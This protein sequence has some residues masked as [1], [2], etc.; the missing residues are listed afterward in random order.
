ML[1]KILAASSAAVV[2]VSAL[3]STA[4]AATTDDYTIVYQ[5]AS[6]NAKIVLDMKASITKENLAN[7]LLKDSKGTTYTA[8]TY[9]TVAA[10]EAAGDYWTGGSD[11]AN[12]YS[13]MQFAIWVKTS[14][15]SATTSTVSIS[16][17]KVSA[18]IKGSVQKYT[19][20]T[21]T[22]GATSGD[23]DLTVSYQKDGNPNTITAAAKTAS[24]AD[25]AYKDMT[26]DM[27]AKGRTTGK[28]VIEGDF[29][30]GDLARLQNIDFEKSSVDV[31]FKVTMKAADFWALVDWNTTND[32]WD[33]ESATTGSFNSDALLAYL[34]GEEGKRFIK[35]YFGVVG[36]SYS[37]K[38]DTDGTFSIQKM[39][40]FGS[41]QL[42]IT[43]EQVDWK[44]GTSY[45]AIG[46]A[47][48]ES[49]GSYTKQGYQGSLVVGLGVNSTPTRL[50]NLNNGGTVTFELDKSIGDQQFASAEIVWRSAAGIV[51]IPLA[52][53]FA[54]GEGGK[55][56]T[57]K[58]PA[59][60]SYNQTLNQYNSFVFEW[61]VTTQWVDEIDPSVKDSDG[62]KPKIVKIT[63]AADK[64]APATVDP[65][66]S[67][68]GGL[69]ES[70]PSST[71]APSS[72][73]STN[74]SG[75][76]GNSEKNPGTGVAVAVAPVVL[77]TA[78]AAVV[79]SK[80]RK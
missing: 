30:L 26:P 45:G 75:N 16:D 25:I 49:Y 13:T 60:L 64:N 12:G 28:G 1:K 39:G 58:M 46:T 70:D 24:I 40:G 8:A 66:N 19:Q 32:P 55:T 71:P 56:I 17:A 51:N 20:V 31:N 80:K 36:D 9:P 41:D 5:K 74:N 11:E 27:Q 62:N 50:K 78:A 54:F 42:L 67:G 3:A 29:G 63:F 73:P 22:P 7:L 21:A 69:V 34:K 10:Q 77:A 18:N 23:P 53:D 35:D 44:E 57:C 65:N 68:N 33:W 76:S 61:K 38:Y 14:T 43:C 2:A 52:S 48:S 15:A 6:D 4:M 79:I 59:G 72:T 37:K 47:F